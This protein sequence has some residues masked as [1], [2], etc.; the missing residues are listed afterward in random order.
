METQNRELRLSKDPK[1][2]MKKI[3]SEVAYLRQQLAD[4]Q[5]SDSSKNT[6]KNDA[7][8]K[9]ELSLEE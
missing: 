3:E 9:K 8:I 5:K 7:S 1:S 4:Y 6:L 2:E